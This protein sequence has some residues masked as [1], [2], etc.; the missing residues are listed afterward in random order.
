[1]SGMQPKIKEVVAWIPYSCIENIASINEVSSF[2]QSVKGTVDLGG[3]TKQA[4]ASYMKKLQTI[5]FKQMV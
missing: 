3:A 5:G 2:V 4:V 1:M